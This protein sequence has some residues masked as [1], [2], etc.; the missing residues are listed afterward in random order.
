MVLSRPLALMNVESEA[1]SGYVAEKTNQNAV[2]D[3]FTLEACWSSARD[4][5]FEGLKNAEK[6]CRSG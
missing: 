4:V 3:M 1:E 5:V 2:V 6:L